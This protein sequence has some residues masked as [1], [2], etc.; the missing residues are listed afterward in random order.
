MPGQASHASNAEDWSIAIADEHRPRSGEEVAEALADRDAEVAVERVEHDRRGLA[1]RRGR[2]G[3]LVGSRERGHEEGPA[4][5]PEELHDGREDPDRRRDRDDLEPVAGQHLAEQDGERREQDGRQHEAVPDQL[6]PQPARVEAA[7]DVADRTAED[8]GVV[9]E[10][11]EEEEEQ[12]EG[13]RER[14]P[15]VRR[16][17]DRGSTRRRL[18]L[19]RRNKKAR[20]S[21]VSSAKTSAPLAPKFAKCSSTFVEITYEVTNQASAQAGGLTATHQ[22]A[23]ASRVGRARAP[24]ARRRRGR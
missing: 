2:V 13:D 11:A 24:A 10:A 18:T 22:S 19:V 21:Q 14:R 17:P 15:G 5:E 7:Q 1:G 9:E 6:Q 23:P 16:P 3:A 4:G 20:S 8:G 12:V